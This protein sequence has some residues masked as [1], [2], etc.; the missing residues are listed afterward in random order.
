L[1]RGAGEN[2]GLRHR[3]CAR[4][5]RPAARLLDEKVAVRVRGG[6]YTSAGA[7]RRTGV[8]TAPRQVFEGEIDLERYEQESHL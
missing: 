4:L 3:A 2:P 8:M 7:V 6:N 1:E 5:C